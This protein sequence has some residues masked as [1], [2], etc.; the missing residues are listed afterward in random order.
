MLNADSPPTSGAWQDVT[1]SDAWQLRWFTVRS[2]AAE[3]HVHPASIRRAIRSGRLRCARLG[4]VPGAAIRIRGSWL[5]DFLERS[6]TPV[7]VS[8]APTVSHKRRAR[9]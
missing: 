9:R 2:S 4:G 5:L 1:Y 6:A 8:R 3:I 7:E